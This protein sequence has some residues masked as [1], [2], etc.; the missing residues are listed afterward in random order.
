MNNDHT[1]HWSTTERFHIVKPHVALLRVPGFERVIL[2]ED[3]LAH[4]AP[5][6]SKSGRCVPRVELH[7]KRQLVCTRTIRSRS[8]VHRKFS[9]LA[10]LLRFCDEQ[11]QYCRCERQRHFEFV[12]PLT[13]FILR[14]RQHELPAK[15]AIANLFQWFRR[16]LCLRHG[17]QFLRVTP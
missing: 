7:V 13:R 11:I 8:N 3:C 4:R 2:S 12:L 17:F 15:I 9:S 16:K 1:A 10:P 5:F 14:H 6:R